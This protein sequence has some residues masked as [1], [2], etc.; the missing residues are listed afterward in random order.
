MNLIP[1]GVFKTSVESGFEDIFDTFAS[2]VTFTL[3]KSPQETILSLDDNFNSDW[4]KT[5]PVK[6]GD[7]NYTEISQSF[8]A[9]IWYLDY[10]QQIKILYFEGQQAE[11][12]RADRS[13]AKV[14]IQ[15]K[16]DAND[17]I[18]EARKAIFLGES[19]NIISDPKSVGIFG[20]KY[21]KGLQEA[22]F[23]KG[24]AIVL[25]YMNESLEKRFNIAKQEFL[26][27]IRQHPV[28]QELENWT[29]PSAFLKGSPYG[30]LFGFLGF[31]AS[32]RPVDDLVTYLEQVV[33]FV[34]VKTISL[35]G[36]ATLDYVR[37][38]E[39]DL[40]NRFSLYWHKGRSWIDAIEHGVSNLGNFLATNFAK[41][42]VSTQG[43]QVDYAVH[44]GATFNGTEYLTQIFN[45]LDINLG[46]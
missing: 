37:P 20:F 25:D 14:K 16:S 24:K 45:N 39:D 30:S 22:V 7:V 40:S 26:R 5:S 23:G 41:N 4:N 13:V 2:P 6:E 42:S 32:Y 18:K 11:N 38:S 46:K 21:Y 43:I 44:T 1:S 31:P 8:P 27:E 19:W 34:P 29:A 15:I 28:S 36:N 33:K 10:E 9:R 35:L 3:Y 17:Y 12:V